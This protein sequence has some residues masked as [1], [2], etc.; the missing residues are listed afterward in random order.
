VS[1][2]APAALAGI[3]YGIARQGYVEF[4]QALGLTPEQVGLSQAQVAAQV[5]TML[6]AFILWPFSYVLVG[7]LG[8]RAANAARPLGTRTTW[9]RKTIL[10]AVTLALVPLAALDLIARFVPQSSRLS[11]AG[12]L[13]VLISAAVAWTALTR[14]I[15]GLPTSKKYRASWVAIILTVLAIA[16]LVTHGE[17]QNYLSNLF[18]GLIVGVGLLAAYLHEG[19]AGPKLRYWLVIWAPIVTITLIAIR[20]DAGETEGSLQLW[21]AMMPAAYI[22]G[23]LVSISRED[24]PNNPASFLER[25]FPRGIPRMRSTE[26]FILAAAL[27]SLGF[28]LSFWTDAR[29]D[30][31]NLLNGNAPSKAL[32]GVL[33]Y[34]VFPV[35]L[36]QL[37]KDTLALCDGKHEFYLLGRN[38]DKSYIIS[39][40]KDRSTNGEVLS[41]PVDDYVPVTG[42]EHPGNCAKIGATTGKSKP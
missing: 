23:I 32:S 5:G 2:L 13:A 28:M 34:Q 42:I 14:P 24:I 19:P 37:E 20:F 18:L 12:R 8:Y 22:G 31:E 3:L 38:G 33:G 6:G 9:S 1:L 7:V 41:I 17:V 27:L 36:L 30:G 39:L 40:R 10:L 21:V 29:K 25:F 26:V 4:Y 16:S 35:K 11:D 15:A